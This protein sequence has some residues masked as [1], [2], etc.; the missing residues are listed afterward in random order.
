MAATEYIVE[1]VVVKSDNNATPEQRSFAMGMVHA[2]GAISSV[3]LEI[4]LDDSNLGYVTI[5][6]D[7]ARQVARVDRH[8]D[9][10]GDWLV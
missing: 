2:I 3:E 7:G 8:G 6:C 5:I 10:V 9:M 4:D 1:N